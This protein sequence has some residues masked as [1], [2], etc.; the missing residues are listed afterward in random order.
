[1]LA[2]H[3]VPGRGRGRCSRAC[4]LIPCEQSLP[5]G[6]VPLGPAFLTGAAS[7][8]GHVYTQQRPSTPAAH[9]TVQQDEASPPPTAPG[10]GR[11]LEG[12]NML[13]TGRG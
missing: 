11:E 9:P 4:A 13:A 12:G 2:S 10:L 1:M 5:G 6:E 7:S 8:G 3:V